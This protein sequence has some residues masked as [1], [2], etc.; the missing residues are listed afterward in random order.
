M[1][2]TTEWIV[3]ISIVGVLLVLS[4]YNY[5]RGGSK[6]KTRRQA[7]VRNDDGGTNTT[8]ETPQTPKTARWKRFSGV[9]LPWAVI[10]VGLLAAAAFKI[11]NTLSWITPEEPPGTETLRD[12]MLVKVSPKRNVGSE[13]FT[14]YRIPTTQGAQIVLENLHYPVWVTSWEYDTRQNKWVQTE[15][16]PYHEGQLIGQYPFGIYSFELDQRVKKDWIKVPV[17]IVRNAKRTGT[18]AVKRES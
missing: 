4:I 5:L 2:P 16:E 18:G 1:E 14:P 8:T 3:V 13:G 9:K 7:T 12:G 17:R 11:S 15:K 10:V 6:S